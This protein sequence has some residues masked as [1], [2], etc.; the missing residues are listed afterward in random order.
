MSMFVIDVQFFDHLHVY[1]FC[2]E[3]YTLK[4]QRFCLSQFTQVLLSMGHIAN[5]LLMPSKEQ[6]RSFL[7][8]NSNA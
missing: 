2:Y 1:Y 8:N 5:M 6:Q 4:E 7:E 3:I